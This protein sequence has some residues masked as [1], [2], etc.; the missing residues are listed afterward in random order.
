MQIPNI[1]E[2]LTIDMAAKLYAGTALTSSAIR[3]LVRSG[4]IP[5]RK[6]GAKYL[7]TSDAIEC[8]LQ[9][10]NHHQKDTASQANGG[11]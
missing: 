11:V 6:I 2:V 1:S 7:L 4:E 8:W 10:G 5:S 3:R 9:G